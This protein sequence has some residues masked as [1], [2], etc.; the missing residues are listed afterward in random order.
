MV[1]HFIS[2]SCDDERCGHAVLSSE[3]VAADGVH[4]CGRPATHKVG[5]EIPHDYP[6]PEHP[7]L[8]GAKMGTHN[9][10]VYVCCEHFGMIFGPLARQNC[11]Q[12]SV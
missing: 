2:A 8:P 1:K 11:Q 9:L 3:H 5:E 6:F 7:E 12:A 4:Y 10:T